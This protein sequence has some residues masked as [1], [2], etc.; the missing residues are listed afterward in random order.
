MNPMVL[1]WLQAPEALLTDR[2]SPRE[3]YGLIKR[4][5]DVGAQSLLVPFVQMPSTS[6]GGDALSAWWRARRYPRFT[7][8]PLGRVKDYQRRA[9]EEICLLVQVETRAALREVDAIAAVDG[10]D[11]VFIGP[12]DLSADMG[13]LG[14][15]THPEVGEAISL[16]V[17]RI[18]AAGKAPGIFALGEADARKWLQHGVLFV[19]LGS[20]LGLLARQSE[21]CLS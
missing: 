15:P 20:D 18:K 21:A 13:H 10:V 1:D 14:D 2:T 4:F 6:G 11:G 8:Q 7:R 3:R 19:A 12:S 9:E 17:E 16:A 5:L